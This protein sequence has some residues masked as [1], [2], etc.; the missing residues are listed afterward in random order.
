MMLLEG[1]FSDLVIK[2][3]R[4]EEKGVRSGQISRAIENIKKS[5]HKKADEKQ[6]EELDRIF[7][8]VSLIK[9]VYY[10]RSTA[11][12]KSWVSYLLLKIGCF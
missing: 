11:C 4:K 10:P 7:G 8:L 6:K 9:S 3:G 1:A 12:S 2:E 5:D